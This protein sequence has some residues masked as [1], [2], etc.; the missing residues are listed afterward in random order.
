MVIF[1]ANHPNLDIPH[2]AIFASLYNYAV[3]IIYYI[4]TGGNFSTE[5]IREPLEWAYQPDLR[6]YEIHKIFGRDKLKN[7]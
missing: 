7:D 1:E 3:K 4:L 6:I 5:C 2:H